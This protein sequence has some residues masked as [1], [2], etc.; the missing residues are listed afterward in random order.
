M[1]ASSPSE[2]V[3]L[4]GAAAEADLHAR[5]RSM[6][7]LKPNLRRIRGRVAVVT[8][9][10]S[11]L[12]LNPAGAPALGVL[13][14][15]ITVVPIPVMIDYPNNSAQM[16][17]EASAELERDLQLAVAQGIGVRTSRP[18]P[19]RF[20]ETYQ[21]LQGRGFSSV[22]SIHISEKLSGTADAARLAAE[23]ADIP[24]A[25][26]DSQQAGLAQGAAVI[27]AAL[28]AR[29]GGS[30]W[31]SAETAERTATGAQS[32]FVVPSL[33]QL[34]RGGRI[35]RLS[36]LVGSM[37]GVRPVLGLRAG[38][39]VLLER[40]RSLPRAID[41]LTDLA[42][43]YAAER[44]APRLGVHFLGNPDQGLSLAEQLAE[45]SSAPVPVV[46]LP[47]ALAAHLGLGALAVSITGG[48]PQE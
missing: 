33:E 48:A 18:S 17:S 28:T 10:A 3:A 2:T 12:P 19:G 39:V 32:L 23:S 29:L 24:V 13:G 8:D 45:H 37:M 9:S 41:R 14:E 6:S 7:G 11:A 40:P 38:E 5:R 20:A 1:A 30:L 26:V 35:N 44:T 36:S 31:D 21:Q 16:Y 43:E 4:W 42:Q 47:P 25:V 27:E 15:H 22:V 46:E 34:R